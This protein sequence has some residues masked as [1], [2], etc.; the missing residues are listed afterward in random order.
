[1]SRKPVVF[2]FRRDLR[3]S[4]NPGLYAAAQEGPVIPV[5]IHAPDEEAFPMGAAARWWLHYSLER[6]SEA[7][8]SLR[9]QLVVLQGSSE[10]VLSD[11][12]HKVA[13]TGIQNP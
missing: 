8:N 6:L 2:W 9:S 11:L 13:L 10:A 5:Y 3:L 12:V 7:L 1:M 4:D